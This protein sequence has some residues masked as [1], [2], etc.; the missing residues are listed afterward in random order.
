[1]ICDVPR[2][3][4]NPVRFVYLRERYP[5]SKYFYS[6]LDEI[7]YGKDYQDFNTE[8]NRRINSFFDN[9]FYANKILRPE[10]YLN[11][12]KIPLNILR[13]GKMLY[14]DSNH[15]TFYGAMLVSPVF[16]EPFSVIAK[17]NSK[18]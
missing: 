4:V 2:W 12:K 7:T 1:M 3:N 15:L 17:N 18:L 5:D 16:D 11:S 14:I 6:C 8:I 13:E 10:I 9:D